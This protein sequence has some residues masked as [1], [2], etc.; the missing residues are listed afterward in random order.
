MSL[1]ND[2]LE[3]LDSFCSR[4]VPLG[5]GFVEGLYVE[6]RFESDFLR[7]LAMGE[8]DSDLLPAEVIRDIQAAIFWLSHASPQK[9]IDVLPHIDPFELGIS[10]L[11][12]R[13]IKLSQGYCLTYGLEAEKIT[14]YD[15]V[16]PV[17]AL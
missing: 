1:Y 2:Q 14:A 5:S 10:V 13:A 7:S 3:E 4:L 8:C 12:T 17:R 11:G 9:D 6:I 16:A 15:V